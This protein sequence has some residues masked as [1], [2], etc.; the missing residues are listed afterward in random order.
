MQTWCDVQCSTRILAHQKSCL[1]TT[2]LDDSLA[3]SYHRKKAR[4]VGF[5]QY[6][7]ANATC[8]VVVL[9]CHRTH[10]PFEIYAQPG[11]SQC[12]AS[13]TPAYRSLSLRIMIVLEKSNLQRMQ[14]CRSLGMGQLVT[15]KKGK[16][17]CLM[18]ILVDFESVACINAFQICLTM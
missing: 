1:I 3:L 8:T 16:R 10:I 12:S 7:A 13:C 2:D 9:W 15:A 4:L 11:C 14:Q 6:C 17:T 5:V 18:S